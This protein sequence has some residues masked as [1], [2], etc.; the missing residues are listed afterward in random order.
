MNKH[1]RAWQET[2]YVISIFGKSPATEKVEQRVMEILDV[3]KYAIYSKGRRKI[4]MAAR[5]LLC[6]WAERELGFTATELAKCLGQTQPAV[7]Y[8]VNRGE[9][10]AK[11]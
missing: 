8:A 7:S 11:E 3:E 1:K 2:D 10:M 4:Q 5:S 6:Y 9:L